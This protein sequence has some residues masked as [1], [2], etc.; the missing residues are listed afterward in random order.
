MLDRT[1]PHGRDLPE[2]ARSIFRL[3][4]DR[5]P[6]TRPVLAEELGIS[7]PTVSESVSLLQ[8]R[9]LIEHDGTVH[10]A[11]GRSASTYRIGSEAGCAIGIDAGST[12]VR[13]LAHT[14]DGRRI[15]DESVM[16]SNQQ[17]H[18]NRTTVDRVHRIA[19]S[20]IEKLQP[21]VRAVTLA[22][23]TSVSPV[24]QEHPDHAAL[25][26]LD[27]DLIKLFDAGVCLENN[28]NCAAVAEHIYGAGRDYSTFAYL[29]LGVKIGLGIIY[30]NQLLR[31]ATRA[32]GEPARIPFAWTPD[33]APLPGRLEQYLGATNFMQRV[34]ENWP[35]ESKPPKNIAQLF[36][37]AEQSGGP[38]VDLVNDY[39]EDVGRLLAAV[40]AVLDPGMVVLGGGVGQSPLLLSS[41]QRTLTNLAW[42][43]EIHSTELGDQA[44][45]LG[46]TSLAVHRGLDSVCSP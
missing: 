4:A 8:D 17:R 43:T 2:S 14:L 16:T 45:V 36:S 35:D 13:I 33:A 38:A 44:T 18:I 3:L 27:R 21:P 40:V 6:T 10:R 31:G 22:V 20:A 15:H 42:R 5:G 11:S 37:Q 39:A 1:L 28:V 9:N 46:A 41:A 30:E 23:P 19:V 32:A 34:R 24:F 29:Q 12:H 7:K 25:V 26:A